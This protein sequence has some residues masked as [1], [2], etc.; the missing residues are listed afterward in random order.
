MLTPL[1]EELTIK[2]LAERHRMLILS[3]TNEL[4]FEFIREKFPVLNYFD[5]FVLSYKI[6]FQKPSKEIF[7][8]AVEKANCLAEECIFTDDLQVNVEAAKKIGI[9]AVQFV[10]SAQFQKDISKIIAGEH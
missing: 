10:S 9:N 7:R 4:H 5:D 2:N 1:I 8:V 6:G 3:D